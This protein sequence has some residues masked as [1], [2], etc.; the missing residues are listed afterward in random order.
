MVFVHILGFARQEG[1]L[2]EATN[3]SEKRHFFSHGACIEAGPAEPAGPA[4]PGRCRCQP[5]TSETNQESCLKHAE[6]MEESLLSSCSS[7]FHPIFILVPGLFQDI[8]GIPHRRSGRDIFSRA[9]WN[10]WIWPGVD[11]FIC[12]GGGKSQ[13]CC[14]LLSRGR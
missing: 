5:E 3:F 14:Q 7:Y 8:I 9:G 6:R 12:C 1:G 11:Q 13:W 2:I 10:R 4:G